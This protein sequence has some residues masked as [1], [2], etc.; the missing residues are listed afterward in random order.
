M[1]EYDNPVTHV[2]FGNTP[3]IWIDQHATG[4]A[5]EVAD[6]LDELSAGTRQPDEK[7]LLDSFNNHVEKVVTAFDHTKVKHR[8]DSLLF[9]D[10]YA[11][12]DDNTAMDEVLQRAHVE[13]LMALLAAEVE[14][15]GP[16]SLSRT[17]NIR[18]A[19]IYEELG[20]RLLAA[21][22]PGKR[23]KTFLPGHAAMAFLRASGL[24][25]LNEDVDAQ[26][27][28]GLALAR[29]RR[30]ATYPAWRRSVGWA[31]D[32]LC[33]YGYRPFRLLGWIAV[34]LL[35][36]TVALRLSTSLPITTSLH[37]CLINFLN[38]VGLGDLQ[39]VGRIGRAVLMIETYAGIVSTSVFFALLV[40]KWF[41]L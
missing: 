2:Q 26:D 19:E 33:G 17:Q 35:V 8:G 25:A 36:F 34:Q 5:Q 29:A 31:S 37:M 4:Y 28:C 27:R 38:P 9:S 7:P 23:T 10:I 39:E 21:A 41:R 1:T 24:H 40:R 6:Y 15:R 11:A 13:L 20:D 3:E 30:S 14:L 12:A 16:L 22:V 32:L 18:L